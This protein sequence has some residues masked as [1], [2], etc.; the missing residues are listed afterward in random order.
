MFNLNAIQYK[1]PFTYDKGH[2]ILTAADK[3]LAF[4]PA[5]NPSYYKA[6]VASIAG[7]LG[8][9]NFQ[10]SSD[11]EFN[12]VG[13]Y[14]PIVRIQRDTSQMPWIY[15]YFMSVKDGFR[16]FSMFIHKAPVSEYMTTTSDFRL[17][18][19]TDDWV[20]DLYFNS[21]DGTE[22]KI[23]DFRVNLGSGAISDRRVKRVFFRDKDGVFQCA[24]QHNPRL[25]ADSLMLWAE[26]KMDV[27]LLDANTFIGE[28]AED[29]EKIYFYPHV[30]VS[31]NVMLE[32]SF[33]LQGRVNDGPV[34]LD[35]ENV[36]FSTFMFKF[37]ASDETNGRIFASKILTKGEVLID[38]AC[39]TD[40][41]KLLIKPKEGF[42]LRK[43]TTHHIFGTNVFRD[44]TNN[45]SARPF[46][47]IEIIRPNTTEFIVK[48]II[49]YDKR[50]NF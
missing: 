5:G 45:L 16:N 37:L 36:N 28:N 19:G 23:D 29:L 40:D 4:Q 9:N 49:V 15:D 38:D 48:G 24:G 32:L 46:F 17:K 43:V 14:F 22:V 34:D 42:N 11:L 18:Q 41:N 27:S 10:L 7:N 3:Q 6:K 35:L 12:G 25:K 2:L 26:I 1:Q 33:P 13:K 47:G 31:G 44:T 39:F 20:A 21:Y 50:K 8:V 30:E